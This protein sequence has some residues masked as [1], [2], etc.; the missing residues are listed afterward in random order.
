MQKEHT[1]TVDGWLIN[2]G[3]LISGMIYSL[4]NAWAYILG[5]IKPDGFYG[6]DQKMKVLLP[7]SNTRKVVVV[8]LLRKKM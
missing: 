3:G 8:L 7:E 6:I 4:A 1:Y 5:V 2:G